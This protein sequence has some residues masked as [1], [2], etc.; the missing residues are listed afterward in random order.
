MKN[1]K[2]EGNELKKIFCLLVIVCVLLLGSVVLV[3][4]HP[5]PEPDGDAY[6]QIHSNI[7]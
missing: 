2:K 3:E 7:H 1:Y 4:S 6:I 5:W